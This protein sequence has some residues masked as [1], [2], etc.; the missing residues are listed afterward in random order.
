LGE[1][2]PVNKSGPIVYSKFIVMSIV[3]LDIAKDCQ[4]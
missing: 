3:H 4:D 2:R 1:S